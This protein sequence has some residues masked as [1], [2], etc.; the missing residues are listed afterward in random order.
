[1]NEARNAMGRLV[2]ESSTGVHG[3]V[4]K[5]LAT[6]LCASHAVNVEERILTAWL[7]DKHGELLSLL[8]A[9]AS[10]PL[11]SA[12]RIDAWGRLELYLVEHLK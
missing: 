8:V 10:Q 1:M 12:A 3:D 6:A 9:W 11:D 7:A 4:A 2:L 5:T